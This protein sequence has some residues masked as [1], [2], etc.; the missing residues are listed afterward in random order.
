MLAVFLLLCVVARAHTSTQV[1]AFPPALQLVTAALSPE[2]DLLVAGAGGAVLRANVS[3]LLELQVH[4]GRAWRLVNPGV[5]DV[6]STAVVFSED[7]TGAG[8]FYVS[9]SA[10]RILRCPTASLL[11][12]N[13]SCE[14]L[15]NSS[16]VD[17]APF[18]SIAA[19]P[20][21][22]SRPFTTIV[23]ARTNHSLVSVDDG[24]TWISTNYTEDLYEVSRVTYHENV[25]LD[26][27][28]GYFFGVGGAGPF[29]SPNASVAAILVSADG[30]S[31][32]V[33]V[34][35]NAHPGWP[36]TTAFNFLA[37]S[38]DFLAVHGCGARLMTSPLT[39]FETW[40]PMII[41]SSHLAP[42]YQWEKFLWSDYHQVFVAFGLPLGYRNS[43]QERW[44]AFSESQSLTEWTLVDLG[45][46]MHAVVHLEPL[47][48][49]NSA[50]ALGNNGE[51]WVSDWPPFYWNLTT[52][53]PF[54]R[55]HYDHF[56]YDLTAVT[57][58]SPASEEVIWLTTGSGPVSFSTDAGHT[59]ISSAPAGVANSSFV[60]QINLED[61]LVVAINKRCPHPNMFSIYTARF[62]FTP[63]SSWTKH[64]F[65]SNTT[66]TLTYDLAVSNSLYVVS[67][68][69]GSHPWDPSFLLMLSD[70]GSNW[71]PVS[72]TGLNGSALFQ[73]AYFGNE[74]FGL[75]HTAGS[76]IG[77]S[78]LSS[79]DA[80]HWSLLASV[81]LN[82][83]VKAQPVLMQ[84]TS[85]IFL[86]LCE[87]P[88]ILSYLEINSSSPVGS[89]ELMSLA[90]SH[91]DL[92]HLCPTTLTA[93]AY[94]QEREQMAIVGDNG[95]MVLSASGA[96]MLD[97]SS[98]RRVKLEFFGQINDVAFDT[99]KEQWVVVGAGGTVLLV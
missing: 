64:Q 22:D 26:G 24:A 41:P 89:P 55:N 36:C 44:L 20:P 63:V 27:A 50:L 60:S 75:S 80:T 28:T 91:L 95:C 40:T 31:W 66:F 45:K 86:F 34:G 79:S 23:A 17:E 16:S 11:E 99:S 68:G 2:G 10:G 98:F 1:G 9:A 48:N 6:S 93:V 33:L 58:Y 69:N 87:H 70:D 49:S 8:V 37:V 71:H 46:D 78:L 43:P 56:E 59:W 14:L 72:P 92:R 47:G 12:V 96:L 82:E 84:T 32:R 21:S 13:P 73:L 4:Q 76:G 35:S 94:S 77:F 15:Y 85:S 83:P 29:S 81:P 52:K 30:I 57:V 62:P 18:T 42:L 5:A 53:N 65:E 51:I 3:E 25:T 7:S 38:S 88:G 54:S 39:S 90:L 19:S 67:V 97:S 61:N 74:F